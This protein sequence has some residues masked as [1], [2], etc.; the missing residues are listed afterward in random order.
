MLYLE[1]WSHL[2]VD[3]VLSLDGGLTLFPVTY[4]PTHQ[5]AH[6]TEVA[7]RD[8]CGEVCFSVA[9]GCG[10][11]A[12]LADGVGVVVG[13]DLLLLAGVELEHLAG[14]LSSGQLAQTCIPSGGSYH[15]RFRPRLL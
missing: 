7:L 8:E 1:Q 9:F 3:V 13:D 14:V 11:L 15:C 6:L 12:T 4:T 5:L 2:L 10:A